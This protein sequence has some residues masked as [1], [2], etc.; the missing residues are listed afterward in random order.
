MGM[1]IYVLFPVPLLCLALVCFPLP[2]FLSG[3]RKYLLK[4]VDVVLFSFFAG[5]LNLYSL[6][7]VIS[8]L[9]FMSTCVDLCRAN[10]K[11]EQAGSNLVDLREDRLRCSKWRCE[12]NFW[13]TLMSTFL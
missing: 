10:T 8:A 12:R 11:L 6:C 3:L 4:G 2:D 13:I 5:P 7:T 9:V 1:L